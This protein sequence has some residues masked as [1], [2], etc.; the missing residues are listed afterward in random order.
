MGNVSKSLIITSWNSRGHADNR[1]DYM[2][3]LLKNTD[4][5]IIQEHW[6]FE[7][8]LNSLV[9]SMDNI[10]VY[11]TSSM[12]PSSLLHGRPYGG[13][14]VLY[15]KHLKCK[16]TPVEV[17]SDRC[18]AIIMELPDLTKILLFNVYMPCDTIHDQ[19]NL[20]LYN[21]VLISISQVRNNHS[22]ICNVII[23]GDFNTDM[24]RNN[25]LHTMS[26]IDYLSS[27]GLV[28]CSDCTLD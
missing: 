17:G 23:G 19:V 4:I 14:A 9:N 2:A 3:K 21:D 1:I 13:C 12:D 7:N 11:G 26:L 22:D 10:Q 5:L 15:N 20:D 28:M 25:S 8:N 18:C 24:S 16:F 27:D 6:F